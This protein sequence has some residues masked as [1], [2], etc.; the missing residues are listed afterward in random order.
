MK[1]AALSL[2]NKARVTL[3]N[4]DLLDGKITYLSRQADPVTRS[5]RVE[6]TVDNPQFSILAGMSGQLQIEGQPQQAHLVSASVMLLD[7]L[8]RL[9]VRAVDQQAVVRSYGI[10][11][12]GESSEGVWVAG[13]PEQVA[14]ITVG[15]NYVT[16]GEQVVVSFSNKR[17]SL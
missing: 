15:Q 7:D 11:T 14:L 10:T 2:G 9:V 17:D 16:N 12:V 6:A 8:G 3:V 1:S 13:L 5:Y 4:G